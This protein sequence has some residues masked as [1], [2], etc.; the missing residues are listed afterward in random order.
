MSIYVC[1]YIYS[2]VVFMCIYLYYYRFQK[3]YDAP[4]AHVHKLSGI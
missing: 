4:G 3:L 2:F 1:L